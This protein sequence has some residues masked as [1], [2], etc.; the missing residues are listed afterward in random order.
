MIVL[1]FAIKV[2]VVV[3]LVLIAFIVFVV[4]FSGMGGQS[5]ALIKGLFGWLNQIMPSGTGNTQPPI[6]IPQVK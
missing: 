2:L 3:L 1:E 5:N 4:F 6:N